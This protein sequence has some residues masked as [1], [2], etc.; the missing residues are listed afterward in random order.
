MRSAIVVWWR[1][2]RVAKDNCLQLVIV[3]VKGDVGR[4]KCE[5]R[6]GSSGLILIIAMH[7]EHRS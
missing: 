3:T 5:G 6:L 1:H 4:V 2:G 7:H